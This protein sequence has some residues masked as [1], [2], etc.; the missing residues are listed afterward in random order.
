MSPKK[1]VNV[2][3]IILIL[4]VLVVSVVFGVLS[5]KL[6][7]TLKEDEGMIDT[8]TQT[9]T[10][11]SAPTEDEE[12]PVVEDDTTLESSDVQDTI[13]EY[14]DGLKTISVDPVNQAREVDLDATV[15]KDYG[16]DP[17]GLDAYAND[18]VDP[19]ACHVTLTDDGY[20]VN[21]SFFWFGTDFYFEV[22][23]TCAFYL[24]WY[25]PRCGIDDNGFQNNSFDESLDE[26]LRANTDILMD[27][28]AAI[29]EVD[30]G[31]TVTWYVIFRYN[32]DVL[33]QATYDKAAQTISYER[34]R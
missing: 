33:L 18:V 1:V 25:F 10:D 26:Y 34:I 16:E 23:D 17:S 2:I 32:P 5:Y 3:L 4:W 29:D 30:N 22:N 7:S 20:S 13:P 12:F 14:P 19:S 24:T 6:Y 9:A 31:D 28:A 11:T 27:N 15:P 8:D 21:G